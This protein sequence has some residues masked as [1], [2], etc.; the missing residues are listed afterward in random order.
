[1]THPMGVA[2]HPL[3]HGF[4]RLYQTSKYAVSVIPFSQ[5]GI[6]YCVTHSRTHVV[7][8]CM[9]WILYQYPISI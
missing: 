6:I 7:V 3:H 9:F 1:M 5:P 2:C 8:H 4:H